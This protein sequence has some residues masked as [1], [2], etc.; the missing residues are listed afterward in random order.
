MGDALA[1][2]NH[3]GATEKPDLLKDLVSSLKRRQIWL[4]CPFVAHLIVA[5][6]FAASFEVAL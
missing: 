3:K 2:G 5:S 1:F 6:L 4:R